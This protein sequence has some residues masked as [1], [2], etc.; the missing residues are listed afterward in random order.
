MNQGRAAIGRPSPDQGRAAIGRLYYVRPASQRAGRRAQGADDAQGAGQRAPTTRK[1]QENNLL[2]PCLWIRYNQTVNK[3][4]F[5][6]C[7]PLS[8]T[9]GQAYWMDSLSS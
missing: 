1:T 9:T 2:V 3:E 4:E 7:N 8:S 6:Q 5:N